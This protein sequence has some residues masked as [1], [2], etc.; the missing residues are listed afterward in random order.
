MTQERHKALT[1][2]IDL[3]RQDKVDRTYPS[4]FQMLKNLTGAVKD[5]IVEA[6]TEG[7]IIVEDEEFLDRM[8]ICIECPRFDP[9]PIRCAECGCFLEVKGRSAAMCCPLYKWPGDYE[10]VLLMEDPNGEEEE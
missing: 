1:D 4:A 7:E 6:V 10:K 2:R 8:D 5:M 9:G 3:M